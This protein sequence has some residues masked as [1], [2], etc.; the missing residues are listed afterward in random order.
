VPVENKKHP[1]KPKLHFYFALVLSGGLFGCSSLHPPPVEQAAA[2]LYLHFGFDL[3][4]GAKRL[5]S[6]RVRPGEVI[7]VGGDDFW[8]LRGM[9][10]QRGTGLSADLTGDN[11]Q[12]SGFCRGNITLEKPF[13]AQGG[14]ASGGA[15]LCWFVVSTNLDSRIIIMR[16]NATLGLTNTPVNHSDAVVHSSPVRTNAPDLIDPATGLP[17]PRKHDTGP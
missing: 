12:E 3:G 5:L 17:L 10:N 15:G 9:I 2:P 8:E 6:T 13:F 14:G 7:F 1:I 11:G 4:Q 16:I